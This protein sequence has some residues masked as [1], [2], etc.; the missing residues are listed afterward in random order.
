MGRRRKP[1]FFADGVLVVNKHAGP[2]SHDV[3]DRLRRRFR[4]ARLGHAGTLDPFATGVLL[5]VFNQA[6]RLADLIG[7]G[8]KLYRG[9]V[10]LGRATDTGDPTGRISE[11]RPVPAISPE[12]ARAALVGL[13][14][15]R[16]QAPPPFSAAKH[17]GRPL[18]SYA[19]AGRPV[20]KPPKPIVVHQARLIALKGE[21]LEFE[22]RLSRGAYVRSLAEDLA[23]ELGTVGHLLRLERV[24]SWPFSVGEA[25]ELERVLTATPAELEEM[26][27]SVAEALARLGL[28]RLELDE[29]RAWQLRQG[30]ILSRDE[31]VSGPAPEPEAG[32][33]FYVVTPQGEPVAV[34][35][36]LEADQEQPGRYYQTIRVFPER[37]PGRPGYEASASACGAE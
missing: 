11:E 36:R 19:R 15:L 34:L 3:V 2:T 8:D 14:G 37:P 12:Q 16:M 24:S 6:T 1:R 26:M 5:L 13:E 30:Q 20:K 9:V 10:G 7:S 25:L 23:R 17:R 29:D 4:P 27:L 28:P 35:R 21:E 32:Q 18:Y 33:P 22:M 31:L